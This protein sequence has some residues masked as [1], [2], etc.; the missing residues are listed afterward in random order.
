MFGLMSWLR[1]DRGL[2]RVAASA[3]SAMAMLVAST[4]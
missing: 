3:G 2:G 1:Q 4:A